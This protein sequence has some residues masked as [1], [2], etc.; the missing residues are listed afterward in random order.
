MIYYYSI[1]IEISEEKIWDTNVYYNKP[2][3]YNL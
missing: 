3:D 1:D 2:Y